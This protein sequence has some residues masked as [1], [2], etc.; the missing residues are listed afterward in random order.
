MF[1]GR[2]GGGR[3]RAPAGMGKES[4]AMAPEPQRVPM[5]AEQYTLCRMAKH[6]VTYRRRVE[7]MALGRES[8]FEHEIALAGER[9]PQI[10]PLG[11]R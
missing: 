10:Y 4:G 1:D 6:D 2:F 8:G 3:A 5:D 7:G 9:Q 11:G